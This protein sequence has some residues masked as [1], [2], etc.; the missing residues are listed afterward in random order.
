MTIQ[1]NITNSDLE[2]SK[3]KLPGHVPQQ[4]VSQSPFIDSTYQD[5]WDLDENL[6]Y[7]T[8]GE[9]WEIFSTSANDTL[10]G[11]GANLVAVNY[12]NDQYVEQQE[13]IALAGTTPVNMAATDAFR[14]DS[15]LVGL[16]GA[17]QGAD[18]EIT[19]RVS[20]GGANRGRIR[21]DAEGFSYNRTY[22][23]HFTVPA[24]KSA[25]LEFNFDNI[26]KGDDAEVMF[27]VM[28]FG[29]N[30]WVTTGNSHIY[31]D[32][33]SSGFQGASFPIPEKAD[34]RFKAHSKNGA[35]II[36][37]IGSFFLVYDNALA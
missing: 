6:V 27:Q 15:M 5:V 29:T 26:G 30:T 32:T 7:P 2:I 9:Q 16:S 17:L 11:T 12:L 34:T 35:I 37:N 36:V 19:I 31:Q 14:F 22:G 4:R 24:G 3:S 28:P 20:G 18:G 21:R 13:I 25:L 8:A 33:L 1:A 10:G 23:S